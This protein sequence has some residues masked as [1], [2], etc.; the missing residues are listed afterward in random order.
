MAQSV[1][2]ALAELL[3]M[4]RTCGFEDFA[5]ANL[6]SLR[7]GSPQPDD[8]FEMSDLY[9]VSAHANL[10]HQSICCGRFVLALFEHTRDCQTDHAILLACD[11]DVTA[12]DE[13]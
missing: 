12:R 5:F 4:D 13:A 6:W 1:L 9:W 10:N 3:S 8:R 11:Y 7:R 2:S